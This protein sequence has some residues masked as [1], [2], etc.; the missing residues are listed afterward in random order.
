MSKRTDYIP[1]EIFEAFQQKSV[2]YSLLIK[3]VAGAG[4]TTLAL[5]LLSI[6]EDYEPIY[7]SSRVAPQS[8]YSQFPWI[9]KKL[10]ETNIIDATRTYLPPVDDVKALKTHLL[11][12]IRFNDVPE[13][14]KII[15]DKIDEE[16]NSIVVIDSWDAI[17]G[18]INGD[19]AS[20]W[21]TILTEFVRQMKVK[22][23][24]VNES[25]QPSYL[26]YIVDGI[27]ELKD[28]AIDERVFRTMG[29][30]KIRGVLRRQKE[31]GFT[32]HNNE[33]IHC[34]AYY[35]APLKEE[36][37]AQAAT[38]TW[39]TVNPPNSNLYSTGSPELDKFY[40]GGLQLSTLNLWEIVSDVPL[41]VFS[42]IMITM[43][44]N[45]ISNGWGTLIYSIDGVNSRFID[46][47]KLFMQLPMNN[48]NNNIRFLV[49]QMPELPQNGKSETRPYV[50]P[51]KTQNFMEVFSEEY[52][53]L[54][55]RTNYNPILSIAA[56]DY[57]MY[58]QNPNILT[59]E[60]YAHLKFA[61]NYNVIGVGIVNHLDRGGS[62]SAP[63][64]FGAKKPDLS[65]FFDTHV[66]MIFKNN[67]IFLYGI[68]PHTEIFWVKTEYSEKKLIP[69]IKLMPMV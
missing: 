45:F 12:T 23:I 37:Y 9:Q 46:K 36:S 34:S 65:Y 59:N 20:E 57:L 27:L 54:T 47:N 41:S 33:F 53:K 68:K 10:K 21:E 14:L 64:S 28:G 18:Q 1:P 35:D 60:V 13:F 39:Q 26:D 25:V 2:G 16:Q 6:F 31:Y 29:V 3:G 17:I 48:I 66:K 67:S 52:Q 61:R 42:N 49:E 40:R 62:E 30:N 11:R 4:K 43:I 51:F 50:V 15:Y 19:K 38:S 7:I 32:L 55:R 58:N 63:S 22:L 56:Y 5:T 8:I 44:S 69:D 24:L